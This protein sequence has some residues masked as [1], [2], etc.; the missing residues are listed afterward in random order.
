M[1]VEIKRLILAFPLDFIAYF[2]L[3]LPVIIGV[4]RQGYL[5]RNLVGTVVFFTVKFLEDTILNY[6]AI[7]QEN[8][9]DQQRGF[10]ILDVFLLSFIYYPSFSGNKFIKTLLLTTTIGSLMA[11]IVNY[12][13]YSSLSLGAVVTRI[14][15][16]MFSLNYFNKMLSENRIK[17]VLK[18]PMFWVSSGFLMFGMGTF[19]STLF[20]DHLL[21]KTKTSYTTY[22]LFNNM[23]Q[24]VI[25]IQCILVAIG[26]WVSKF[27]QNNYMAWREPL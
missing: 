15:L 27:D 7:R 18:H 23:N 2:L 26:L 9:L 25:S 17:N 14:I 16:I 10:F 1:L 8:N 20:T 24:I 4:Y 13:F 3:L 19:M 21:D 22:I 12:F 5:T 6:Y 11:L